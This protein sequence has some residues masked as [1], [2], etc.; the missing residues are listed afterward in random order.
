MKQRKALRM[1]EMNCFIIKGSKDL[2]FRREGERYI[3]FDPIGLE[4]YEINETGACILFLISEEQEYNN[5]VEILM[6]WFELQKDV[7]EEYIQSFLRVFPMK[8]LIIH[9]LVKLGVPSECIIEKEEIKI[10]GS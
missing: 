9:N 8:N 7:V 10:L 6:E 2:I 3:C 4:F 5:M 1:D